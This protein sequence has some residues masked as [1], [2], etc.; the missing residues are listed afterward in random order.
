MADCHIQVA[1]LFVQE[2]VSEVTLPPEVAFQVQG[3]AIPR[4]VQDMGA[5][6]HDGFAQRLLTWLNGLSWFPSCDGGF[7]VTSALALLWQFIYDTGGLPPFWY[8][9]SW[10]LVD[11]ALAF[12]FVVPSA[13]CLYRT[14]VRALSALSLQPGTLGTWAPDDQCDGLRLPFGKKVWG[15]LR[16]G[17]PVVADL[18]AL[19][20]RSPTL[21][22]LRLPGFW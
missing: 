3:C 19:A 8:E 20:A 17:P 12:H 21:R 2:V 15:C 11:D 5:Q 7:R 16:L 4:P 6:A 1:D 14:W 9:G 13:A 10:R 22:S 18:L